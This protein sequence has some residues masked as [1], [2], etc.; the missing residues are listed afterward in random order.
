MA[1]CNHNN[2]TFNAAF[3][4]L[5]N[6]TIRK[7]GGDIMHEHKIFYYPYAPSKEKQAPLLEEA[8][9]YF[10]TLYILDPLKASWDRVGEAEI[11]RDLKLHENNTVACLSDEKYAYNSMRILL[12]GH[13]YRGKREGNIA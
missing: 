10:D 9:L 7:F 1:R 8:A 13:L 12:Q 11:G 2:W 3:P 6:V 5:E 4:I